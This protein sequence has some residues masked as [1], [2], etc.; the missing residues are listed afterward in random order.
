M[1]GR[2]SSFS[3]W[4]SCSS[5][6]APAPS[7]PAR[8]ASE[9]SAAPAWTSL[10]WIVL[11]LVAFLTLAL[12]AGFIVAAALQFWL[13]ARAFESR[14]PLRDLLVAVF[15]A[16]VVYVAFAKGLGLNLPSGRLENGLS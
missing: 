11:S 12:R 2:G 9:P 1:S 10:A 14:R 3:A 6:D 15:L 7:A 4:P 16:V 8:A 5:A 13:A